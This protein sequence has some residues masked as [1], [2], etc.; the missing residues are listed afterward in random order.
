MTEMYLNN[1]ELEGGFS[2]TYQTLFTLPLQQL[3]H[4]DRT[5][6]IQYK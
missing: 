3:S 6:S 5:I 1:G 2:L 4:L